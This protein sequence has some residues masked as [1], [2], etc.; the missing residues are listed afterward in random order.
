MV[1]PHCTARTIRLGFVL[2][3]ALL[4]I[5]NQ[6][7]LAT[8]GMT[9]NGRR[10]GQKPIGHLAERADRHGGRP[11]VA[12]KLGSYGTAMGASNFLRPYG[13]CA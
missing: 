10:A 13:C 9:V 8:K 11:R 3:L 7:M 2:T 4:R 1:Y 12:R 5:T 6:A